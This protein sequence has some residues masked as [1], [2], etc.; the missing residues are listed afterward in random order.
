MVM[1]VKIRHSEK[2][3]GKMVWTPRVY[4][5]R[6]GAHHVPSAPTT[7]VRS[8]MI[9]LA[10]GGYPYSHRFLGESAEWEMSVKPV[11]QPTRAVSSAPNLG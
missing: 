6:F 5:V 11:R 3:V 9:G 8:G 2:C 7:V 1:W 4:A 10:T